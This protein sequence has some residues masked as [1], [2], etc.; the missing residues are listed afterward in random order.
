M[1]APAM[2][3][4]GFPS[5]EAAMRWAIQQASAEQARISSR[6]LLQEEGNQWDCIFANEFT[7]HEATGFAGARP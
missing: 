6:V 2:R 5:R 4:L 7:G 1:S 3:A